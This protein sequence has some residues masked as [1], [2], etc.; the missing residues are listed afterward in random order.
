MVANRYH[1]V[2]AWFGAQSSCCCLSPCSAASPNRIRSVSAATAGLAMRRSIWRTI[3][4]G[5]PQWHPPGG[6]PEH[7]RCAARLSQRHAGRRHAHP[8][9]NAAAAGQRGGARPGDHSGHQR[10]SWRRCAVRPR[11]ADQPQDLAGQRI[12][13][14]NTALGAYFLS[15]VLDQ[16]GLRI[17]DLQVV[18]LPVH[19]Q[20]PPPRRRRSRR[21]HHL[22][23]GGPGAGKQGRPA[24][25]R[26]PPA[27]GRDRRRTG[28]RPATRHPRAASAPPPS[29]SMRCAP[30]RT[31][32]AKPIPA[33]MR[34][35]A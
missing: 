31:I 16:A 12:G 21:C 23:F 33:C 22:R 6:I 27:A 24:H 19:E 2:I 15:R 13:V 14:E 8:R 26:Q 29:G 18:S 4:A 10:L 17:D 20:A 28:G 11:A 32:A 25:L 7:H 5:L 9:R 34:A 35:W 3:W 30:G 1:G